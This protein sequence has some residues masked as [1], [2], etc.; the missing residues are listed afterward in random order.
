MSIVEAVQTAR[1]PQEALV[2]I[3][4][5]LERLEAMLMALVKPMPGGLDEWDEWSEDE[6][7]PQPIRTERG[8]DGE[9]VVVLPTPSAEVYQ[10]RVELAEKKMRLNDAFPKVDFDPVEVYAK[11]GPSWL[12]IYDRD[13]VM[14]MPADVKRDLVNDLM[15]DDP[16]AAAE[17]A[18]DILKDGQA[19]PPHLGDS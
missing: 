1:N 2:V 17:M 9:N 11:G 14:G 13:L 15:R 16:R 6:P 12:Y 5:A 10:A 7:E 19:Q 18:R 8:A 4:D 3:A